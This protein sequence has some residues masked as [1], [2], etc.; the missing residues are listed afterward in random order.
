[1]VFIF[2]GYEDSMSVLEGIEIEA[3]ETNGSTF[4]INGEYSS[5]KIINC[6]FNKTGA[7]FSNC[8]PLVYDCLFHDA[9][10]Y[11]GGI[12]ITGNSTTSIYIKNCTFKNNHIN[13]DGGAI[14]LI[15]INSFIEISNYAN[16]ELKTI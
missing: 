5:P 4:A 1:M 2:T 8:S 12:R 10:Y 11:G 13:Y 9:P 7:A 15:S 6:N 3:I 14:E 16:Q